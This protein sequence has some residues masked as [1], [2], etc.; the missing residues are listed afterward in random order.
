MFNRL[1]MSLPGPPG[2]PARFRPADAIG[3]L[4]ARCGVRV[5]QGPLEVCHQAIARIN[6][7]LHFLPLELTLLGQ[8]PNAAGVQTIGH[9]GPGPLVTLP[10][11]RGRV[12][13]AE[14]LQ[15]LL[16]LAFRQVHLCLQLPDGEPV[17]LFK[18]RQDVVHA[19]FVWEGGGPEKL[20]NVLVLATCHHQPQS[21][22]DRPAGPADLL[23]IGYDG[24]RRLVVNHETKVRFVVTHAQDCGRNQ[25]LQA[26]VEELLFQVLP[27]CVRIW[28]PFRLD[29]AVIGSGI[30]SVQPQPFGYLLGILFRQGV[31]YSGA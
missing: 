15:H 19:R 2:T 5:V 27:A 22:V 30:D 25:G 4:S 21:P 11:D 6:I 26:V 29:A 31:D 1:W 7:T 28:K 13:H 20:V 17:A 16:D 14:V 23:V 18:R 9:R 8:A 12:F 3:T 24:T 10:D